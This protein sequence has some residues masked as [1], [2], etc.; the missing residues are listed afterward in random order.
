MNPI[1]PLLIIMIAAMLA[2]CTGLTSVSGDQRRTITEIVTASDDN[3]PP[4]KI[5]MIN[6][7]N[8]PAA[9]GRPAGQNLNVWIEVELDKK[10]FWSLKLGTGVDPNHHAESDCL[11]IIENFR[12]RGLPPEFSG[13][14]VL[15]ELPDKYVGPNNRTVFCAFTIKRDELNNM[16][17]PHQTFKNFRLIK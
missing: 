14:S 1:K 11:R 16:L 13:L 17:P 7:L 4:V 3:S 9:E 15:A 6:G 8:T 12:K 2:G 5:R 10:S